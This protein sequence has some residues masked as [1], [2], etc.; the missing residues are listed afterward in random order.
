MPTPKPQ[1]SLISA[2]TD[3]PLLLSQGSEAMFSAYLQE[4]AGDER[5]MQCYDAFAA[6]QDEDDFWNEEDPW[7]SSL[8]PYNVQNGVLTIPVQGVL[9]NKFSFQ[10]G[11]RAT[12]YQ[13]IEK[14]VARGLADDDVRAIA[15]DINSPGGEVAGNFE[16]AE[17][18]ANNRAEKRMRSF[19][20]DHAYSA[21]YNIA[22]AASQ[23]VMARSGGVGSV[24]VVVAH[25]EM[26]EMLK[27]W[28]IK[29]TFI[30]AGKYKVDGN[31]YE[32]LS[33]SAKS[34]LQARVDRIYGEFVAL[35]AANRGMDESAVRETE[36]LTYDSSE[37]IEVGFADRIGVISAEMA[38]FAEEADTQENRF[39]TTKSQDNTPAN[40]GES[41][42]TQAQFDQAVAAAAAEGAT[43]ERTRIN[44][45]LGSEEGKARPKAALSAALKTDLSAEA[46]TAFLADLPEEKAEQEAAAPEAAVQPAQPAQ[47]N[48]FNEAMSQTGNPNVGAAVGDSSQPEPDA[49]AEQMLAAYGQVSGR[50]MKA[51]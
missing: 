8:R 43:A 27:D 14:A 10:F 29:V 30:H 20:N 6:R 31:P 22:A 11:R 34:R 12:G 50:K 13:Y 36:A 37:A 38:S 16:L 51:A 19:A 9:L 3:Q 26:S 2:I 5:F 15:F 24:G 42:I 23:I 17:Y 46:A 21:G 40:T 44:A 47:P 28:G 45:I 39:M 25:V 18:I 4:L 48:G 49:V 1:N 7:V 33:D 35:V 41:Q 32:K